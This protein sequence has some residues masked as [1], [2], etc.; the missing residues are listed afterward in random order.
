MD[1]PAVDEGEQAPSGG[2][3]PPSSAAVTANDL[4]P[5]EKYR[6]DMY[7]SDSD[8]DDEGEGYTDDG[9]SHG[10][11]SDENDDDF[12]PVKTHELSA[13]PVEGGTPAS[14]PDNVWNGNNDSEYGAPND[15]PLPDSMLGCLSDCFPTLNGPTP[16]PKPLTGAAA[17]L[18]TLDKFKAKNG[19]VDDPYYAAMRSA[20][21][22]LEIEEREEGS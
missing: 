17:L 13:T 19:G 4:E 12:S 3:P 14:D 9:I 2:P 6:Q 10:D 1:G 7:E 16:A 21:E 22:E 18:E 8:D 15:P 11:E 5:F 20:L